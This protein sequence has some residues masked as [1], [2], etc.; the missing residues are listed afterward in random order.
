MAESGR[1]RTITDLAKDPLPGRA[2]P[3]SAPR[4]AD[5]DVV[6]L[7]PA[8]SEVVVFEVVWNVCPDGSAEVA[9]SRATRSRQAGR[10]A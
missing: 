7:D 3:E 6:A 10:L 5:S 2:R 4:R 8:P 1:K 9:D